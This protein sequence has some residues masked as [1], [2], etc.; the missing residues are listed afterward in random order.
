MAGCAAALHN[1]V[2]AAPEPV[3]VTQFDTL[4]KELRG[5]PLEADRSAD[6]SL[7]GKHHDPSVEGVKK[8]L[9]GLVQTD[10][11]NDM[12]FQSSFVV[13]HVCR[14]MTVDA[15]W[16]EQLANANKAMELKRG[17]EQFQALPAWAKVAAATSLQSTIP[18]NS[19]TGRPVFTAMALSL[20]TAGSGIGA[21]FVILNSASLNLTCTSM[22]TTS[23]WALQ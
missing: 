23:M 21:V 17:I 18:W 10:R 13:A 1:M 7:Q 9:G 12:S 11:L 15:S 5:A 3:L 16:E 22:P 20:K 8:M 4:K 2:K 19:G 6:G 14:D